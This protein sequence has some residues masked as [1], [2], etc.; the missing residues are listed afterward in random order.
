MCQSS[1]VV[2]VARYINI[3]PVK[4]PATINRDGITAA[5]VAVCGVAAVV[6]AAVVPPP[7]VVS[8]PLAAAHTPALWR[9]H[10]CATYVCPPPPKRYLKFFFSLWCGVEQSHG[11]LRNVFGCHGP[12][13]GV[14]VALSR[15]K[16]ITHGR[17]PLNHCIYNHCNSASIPIQDVYWIRIC[18]ALIFKPFRRIPSRDG[19]I[20]PC[21]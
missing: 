16:I 10:F 15:E 17:E 8:I 11:C 6:A 19:Y 12:T 7:Y 14:G 20:P 13:E 4:S 2:P 9:D 18:H 1:I 3:L 5:R 21:A